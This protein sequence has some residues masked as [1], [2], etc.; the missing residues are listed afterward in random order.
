MVAGTREVPGQGPNA[1]VDSPGLQ[2]VQEGRGNRG[3]EKGRDLPTSPSTAKFL[4][5]LEKWSWKGGHI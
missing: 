1:A 5:T 2:E 3:T 4:E